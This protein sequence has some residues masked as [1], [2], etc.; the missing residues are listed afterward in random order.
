MIYVSF[1][2]CVRPSGR[3]GFIGMEPLSMEGGFC[4]A[5]A[6]TDLAYDAVARLPGT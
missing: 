3:S 6:R 5:L 1:L 4:H 2:S